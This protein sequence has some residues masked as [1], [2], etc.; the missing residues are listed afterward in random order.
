MLFALACLLNSA[1]GRKTMTRRN[2]TPCRA[3][4]I[5]AAKILARRFKARNQTGRGGGRS[6]NAS[7]LK[8]SKTLRRSPRQNRAALRVN[9]RN[10]RDFPHAKNRK[11]L[12]SRQRQK[13][14]RR[15]SLI[16]TGAAGDKIQRSSEAKRNCQ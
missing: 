4:Q 9:G 3:D 15:I 16:K 14:H 2:T 5:A 13:N 12:E 11:I 8:N 7:V 6:L 10:E 1:A